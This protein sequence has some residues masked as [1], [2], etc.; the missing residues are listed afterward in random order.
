MTEKQN[1]SFSEETLSIWRD[2]V[3]LP[4][5][6]PLKEDHTTDVLVVGAGITG[7]TAA[8]ML[9]KRGVSV[10]LIDANKLTSGTT[11][12]TTAKISAQHGLIYDHLIRSLGEENAALYYQANKEGLH[13]I[14]SHIK[15][16]GLHCDFEI[17]PSLI[18]ATNDQE[19]KAVEKEKKAYDRLGILSSLKDSAALPFKVKNAL[20]MPGQAQFHPL[21]YLHEL[22]AELVKMNVA[23]FEETL[24]ETIEETEKERRVKTKQGFTINCRDVLICSH[25]PFY[26]HRFYFARMFAERSYLLAC[27]TDRALPDG[28]YLSAGNPKRSIRGL[29]LNQKNYLLI[30]GENHKTG[31][32]ESMEHH[33]E[34]L[35]SFAKQQFG[36]TKIVAHWSAQDFTTLDQVPYIGRIA[37]N[38]PHILVAAGFHKWGMTTGTLAAQL[39][40][41]L[42]LGRENPYEALFSPSRF[43]AT[44]ML[45][46]FLAENLQVAGQLIK[47]KL[48]RPAPLNEHLQNDQ[49]V[50]AELHG[51]RVGAYRNGKGELTVVDTT[52]PH[53]GCE[54]NWNQGEKSWDCPCHGSRFKANGEVIDGPAKDALTLFF[55]EAGHE[56]R[57]ENKE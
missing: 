38:S 52:C 25:F 22:I 28:M 26:D 16:N 3:H 21:M 34:Q 14:G 39:L 46:S 31:R 50:I 5:F 23:I 17:Q 56:K 12:Y 45:A 24:A 20:I 55:S 43:E 29:H 35:A 48:S 47:G 6:N 41:D 33:Y 4:T 44:P 11:G 49:A 19:A 36:Q 27:E 30:G 2:T 54:V 10:T 51:E 42:V 32:G 53:L 15:E 18:Y 37:K 57:A 9:A 8:Y 7:I 1:S 40:T 13:W